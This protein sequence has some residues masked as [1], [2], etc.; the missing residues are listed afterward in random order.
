MTA[1]AGALDAC[2]METS[3]D[4]V[5]R[6]R[7]GRRPPPPVDLE[8]R[9]LVERLRRGEEA[10]FVLL[11]ERYQAGLLR[12]AREFVSTR[13]SAEEVVQETWLGV[14]RGIDRFEGRSSL[15]TW[16][17]RILINRARS[18]GQRD[19]RSTPFSSA[20][21]SVEDEGPVVEPERFLGPEHRWAGHWAV[22]PQRWADAPERRLLA[23]EGRAV[24]EEAVAA[25][26][27]SQRKV[28]VLHDVQGLE[29]REI[30][31]LMGLSDVNQRVLLHRA[32]S[33]V[34]A[35]LERYFDEG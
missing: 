7:P 23:A 18:K 24:I 28:I 33:K 8:E 27:P 34:R 30:R 35:A 31:D 17:H 13:E 32:R 16:I 26:P 19:A 1:A 22:P 2:R 12:L 3:A 4:A 21:P 11:V 25:L 5:G 15:R 9:R 10:A 20:F 6:A 29:A 14:L